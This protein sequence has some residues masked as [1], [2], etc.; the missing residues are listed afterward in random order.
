MQ[1]KKPFISVLFCLSLCLLAFSC[2]KEEIPGPKGEPGTNGTGGNSNTTNSGVFSI[3]SSA[4][5]N[6]GLNWEYTHNT[7]LITKDV[8][9]KGA[10][11]VYTEVGGV[12]WELPFAE[13]DLL[14]Q[15]GF[16]EGS[17]EFVHGDLHMADVPDRPETRNF[18]FVILTQSA[19]NAKPHENESV[20]NSSSLNNSL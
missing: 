20:P 7:S 14:T 6:V 18:R 13:G 8:V 19:K 9:E 16:K 4:W 5:T 3:T 10:I 1:T 11:K 15:F 17:I 12:W 2:A